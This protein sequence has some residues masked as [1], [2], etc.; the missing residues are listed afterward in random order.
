MGDSQDALAL[1]A[2][3]DDLWRDII[4]THG[5]R[6]IE[7]FD[8]L[9]G[10]RNL[11]ADLEALGARRPDFQRRFTGS[12]R[13]I[14][15]FA[16]TSGHEALAI[17]SGRV[18]AYTR[19][20]KTIR[21]LRGELDQARQ[22][23]DAGAVAKL[24]MDLGV[25]CGHFARCLQSAFK[26]WDE[27]RAWID[28]SLQE[29]RSH[30]HPAPGDPH[31]TESIE[32][33]EVEI[34]R[35]KLKWDRLKTECTTVQQMFSLWQETTDLLFRTNLS[36]DARAEELHHLRTIT[37]A[38][39]SE[40]HKRK[41]PREHLHKLQS[42]L[43]LL[44]PREWFDNSAVHDSVAR[45]VHAANVEVQE[46]YF[47]V[48]LPESDD[49]ADP[50][51]SL[52]KIALDLLEESSSVL[53]FRQGYGRERSNLRQ[54][55]PGHLRAIEIEES[56]ARGDLYHAQ[57]ML[58]Q[59]TE[60]DQW[61]GEW[62]NRY[63][64]ARMSDPANLTAARATLL[65]ELQHFVAEAEMRFK[66]A[67]AALKMSEGDLLKADRLLAEEWRAEHLP[68]LHE[69][70]EQ[71]RPA[72][73]RYR[74]I[75]SGLVD[76]AQADLGS[77]ARSVSSA[78]HLLLEFAQRVANSRQQTLQGLDV[79]LLRALVEREI[80]WLARRRFIE[81]QD[82]DPLAP[83]TAPP[84]ASSNPPSAKAPQDLVTIQ[85]LSDETGIPYPTLTS[86]KNRLT[87]DAR[88]KPV[89]KDSSRRDLY[90][91]ADWDQI[92]AAIRADA[93]PDA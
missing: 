10:P 38:L 37:F 27:N 1:F 87:G 90:H 91:R 19:G 4:G 15:D 40:A 11:H 55:L 65:A 50:V 31:A 17:F 82:V 47:S 76:L 6:S 45:A 71:F 77:L 21:R 13:T 18:A 68:R 80:G 53:Q 30:V 79:D 20:R 54:R 9:F 3:L 74:H 67:D 2:D 29:E 35:R 22:H 14:A 42:E 44:M 60:N 24:E 49:A 70:I 92:I 48:V 12:V 43:R 32:A 34:L 46:L 16:V 5:E 85:G 86:R 69:L 64:Q 28:R 72:F 58:Q 26:G 33:E 8:T 23:G 84:P 62:G 39:A 41:R 59:A 81:R 56:Q 83:R 36:D 89:D 51:E 78:C 93:E 57:H 25:A 7:A 63:R 52:H 75:L 66:R 73:E 88:L 61:S